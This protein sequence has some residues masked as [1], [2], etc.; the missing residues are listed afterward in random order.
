[1]NTGTVELTDAVLERVQRRLVDDDL[2]PTPR[3]LA[4]A[5]RAESAVLVS[6]AE[7]LRLIRLLQRELVGAGPLADLLADPATTDVVVNSPDDV[8]VDRGQG[9]Q[10]TG[11][12]FADDAAVQRLA[13]RLATAAGRR[14]DDAHP[15][16]DARMADGTR[17]HA[18]LAPV[19]AS[20]SCLSLRILRP[21]RHDLS[22][23]A[24][25]GSLPGITMATLRAV[26]DARLSLLVSGGTGSGK[27]TLLSALLAA[28]PASERLVTVE[29]AEEL[30]PPH[31]HVVRLVARQAN[32]EG[33]GTISLR[34]L[35]RQALRMRPDR[36]V[37]GEVRGAE[38]VD[39]L[40]AL[41]TGHEGGAGTVHANT[42]ADVPARLEAL[43]GLG[44][45]GREA[46]HS[47]LA[48]A[49]RIVLH[50]RRVGRQRVLQEIAVL[51]RGPDGLVVSVP[52]VVDG[53]CH[54][55]GAPLLARLLTEHGQAT[56][57]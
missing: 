30:R 45:I 38:V 57:W 17:L 41:N 56:P 32:V 19:A 5:L 27:T 8:R 4:Q 2:E 39:L 50:V 51:E 23:L 37:V 52:A 20:G 10:P 40:A 36:I 6:D 33:A 1:M 3:A 35:V 34:D 54:P 24:A 48:G 18:V 55:A 29:D 31:P 13:R 28:V 42:A 15:H 26:L 49:V 46:L 14:L 9:W 44:G 53:R 25:S 12:V 11:V 47:Q 7:M 16:V 43:A 22:A 21:A